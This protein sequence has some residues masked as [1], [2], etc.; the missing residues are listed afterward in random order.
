MQGAGDHIISFVD[1]S[2][3]ISESVQHYFEHL[4]ELLTRLEKNNLILKLS[5]SNFFKKETKFLGFVLT[6]EGIKSDPDKVQGITDFP[7]P[8]NVKQLRG[9]LGLVNFYSKFSSMHGEETVPLL[10]LVKKG[11]QWKWDGDMQGC[12]N[13]VKQLVSKTRTLYFPDPKKSY[14][15]ETDASNYALVLAYIQR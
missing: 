7:T 12:F 4:E 6:T 1:D 11:A 14:Y 2:R 3:V 9:F 13:R 5:K 10:H 8:K 15:L